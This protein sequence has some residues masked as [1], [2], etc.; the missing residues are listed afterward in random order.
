[1]KMKSLILQ[2]ENDSK[3]EARCSQGWFKDWSSYSPDLNPIENIRGLMKANIYQK[4]L[5][6]IEDMKA[7]V[8][9][10]QLIGH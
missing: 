4:G 3:Y 7:E 5:S 8:G 6:N 10:G 2:Y 1:M 9:T